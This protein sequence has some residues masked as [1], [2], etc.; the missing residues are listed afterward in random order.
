MVGH[1]G[2]FVSP[3]RLLFLAKQAFL[4]ALANKY[5]AL[6]WLCSNV[7]HRMGLAPPHL[8]DNV[9]RQI[10]K[11]IS[12][13]DPRQTGANLNGQVS[14]GPEPWLYPTICSQYARL[15]VSC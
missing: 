2:L 1:D 4:C 12:A 11:L 7:G 10:N 3:L 5:E 9:V 13:D 6:F 15:H 8:R 14:L